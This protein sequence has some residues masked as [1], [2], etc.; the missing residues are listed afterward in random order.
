MIFPKETGFISISLSVIEEFFEPSELQLEELMTRKLK[1]KKTIDY[2]GQDVEIIGNFNSLDF[3]IDDIYNVVIPT[4][5]RQAM[6]ITLWSILEFETQEA[7]LFAKKRSNS[8]KADLIRPDKTSKFKHSLN[9]LKSLGVCNNSS[10]K[11]NSSVKFL[12]Q[13]VR[14]IRNAWAHNGG[15]INSSEVHTNIKN[16][17][18][19]I[20]LTNDQL[21]ISKKYIQKIIKEMNIF[22]IEL[23]TSIKENILN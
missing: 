2:P 1:S 19:G 5:Q 21:S 10:K 17:T 8:N 7:Y 3:D 15:K 4:Y 20:T 22:S 18:D 13:Q 14:F 16:T 6:I 9:N 11:F 23:N 12:D